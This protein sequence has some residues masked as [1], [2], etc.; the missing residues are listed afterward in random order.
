MIVI[1]SEFK[2]I[3]SPPRGFVIQETLVSKLQPQIDHRLR[4][5]AF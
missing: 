5:A 1:D 2:N 3:A 4:G